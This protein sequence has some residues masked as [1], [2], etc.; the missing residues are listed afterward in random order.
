MD[1]YI[2]S[3]L[4]KSIFVFTMLYAIISLLIMILLLWLYNDLN[5]GDDEKEFF[6]N[7]LFNHKRKTLFIILLLY[8]LIL[9][10]FLISNCSKI[11]ITSNKNR[12][13]AHYT[14]ISTAEPI[15]NRYIEVTSGIIES[16]RAKIELDKAT[17]L[18][19][20]QEEIKFFPLMEDCENK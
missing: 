8:F 9:G 12:L 17:L 7:I 20:F 15:I 18:E 10:I 3:E 14:E 19:I 4:A 16:P 2:I 11:I 5:L 13:I 6:E 1:I